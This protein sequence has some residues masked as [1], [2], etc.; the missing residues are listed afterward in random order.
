MLSKHPSTL[1][2][3]KLCIE[4]LLL[5]CNFAGVFILGL[6]AGRFLPTMKLQLSQLPKIVGSGRVNIRRALFSCLLV[7]IQSLDA[8]R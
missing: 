5:A 4:F 1:I 7:S 3:N 2:V 6:Y 8:S